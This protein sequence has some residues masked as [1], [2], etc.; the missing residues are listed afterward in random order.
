[1]LCCCAVMRHDATVRHMLAV[2]ERVRVR[3]HALVAERKRSFVWSYFTVANDD[4]VN[5][6]VY[7]RELIC[8]KTL[9]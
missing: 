7:R 8:L 3:A 6:D 2:W 1:M 5:C 9:L 4:I